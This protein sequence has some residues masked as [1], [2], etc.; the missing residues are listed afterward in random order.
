MIRDAGEVLRAEPGVAP[1]Q[2]GAMPTE[3]ERSEDKE[4]E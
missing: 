4:L 2:A 1:S 3:R